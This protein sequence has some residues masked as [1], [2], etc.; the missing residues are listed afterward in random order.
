M[1]LLAPPRKRI[2]ERNPTCTTAGTEPWID[3]RPA[4]QEKIR[5]PGTGG[6]ANCSPYSGQTGTLAPGNPLQ[7]VPALTR[8]HSIALFPDKTRIRTACSEKAAGDAACSLAVRRQRPQRCVVAWR[9]RSSCA[10][11]H[12]TAWHTGHKKRRRP[13]RGTRAFVVWPYRVCYGF[14]CVRLYDTRCTRLRRV[15]VLGRT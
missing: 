1:M 3:A 12:P 11:T 13:A 6:G 4:K 2:P 14:L 7:D 10:C 15:R 8:L 5:G 9:S